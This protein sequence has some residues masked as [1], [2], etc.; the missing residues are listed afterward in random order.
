[1]TVPGRL[2]SDRLSWL[3]LIGHRVVR[4]PNVGGD[5]PL[6]VCIA[7][8]RR[9]RRR[10]RLRHDHQRSTA[11]ARRAQHA[12]L[13]FGNDRSTA[14]I[15]SRRAHDVSEAVRASISFVRI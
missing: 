10:A 7:V 12:R 3:Y 13:R 9:R 8:G 4:R 11:T 15:H 2:N 14:A 6:D 1:M 5:Q